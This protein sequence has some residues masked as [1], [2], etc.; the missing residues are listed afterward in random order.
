MCLYMASGIQP[1]P[2]QQLYASNADIGDGLMYRALPAVAAVTCQSS[3]ALE[4]CV[5]MSVSCLVACI[6]WAAW[7]LE[8][9]V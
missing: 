7:Q 5:F 6:A 2:L 3:E 8:A 4:V 1:Q 9:V